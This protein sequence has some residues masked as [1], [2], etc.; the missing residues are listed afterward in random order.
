[1]HKQLLLC[2]QLAGSIWKRHA[3]GVCLSLS[4]ITEFDLGLKDSLILVLA[5]VVLKVRILLTF[6][7]LLSFNTLD[8]LF[9][10]VYQ[11][12][13]TVASLHPYTSDRWGAFRTNVYLTKKKSYSKYFFRYV[14]KQNFYSFVTDMKTYDSGEFLCAIKLW[15]VVVNCAG[16]GRIPSKRLMCN[17]V[18]PWLTA[19]LATLAWSVHQELLAMAHHTHSR[20]NQT[21]IA[22][23]TSRNGHTRGARLRRPHTS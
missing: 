15:C 8:W 4:E 6:S 16:C 12:L 22:P 7:D 14:L 2:S 10:I 1:M 18:W 23:H 20:K 3:N 21:S 9:G 17:F 13:I 19:S 5:V 11:S